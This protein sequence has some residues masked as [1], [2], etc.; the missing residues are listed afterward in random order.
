M[1]YRY[2]GV[3]R[4]KDGDSRLCPYGRLSSS[5]KFTRGLT[6]ELIFLVSRL[7][8]FIINITIFNFTHGLL[9]L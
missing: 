3:T 5:V 7:L 6:M 9:F 4:V 8:R 1:K 2:T